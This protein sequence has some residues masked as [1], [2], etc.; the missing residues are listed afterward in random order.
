MG[1]VQRVGDANSGGGAVE[2][3]DPTVRVNNRAVALVGDSVT[4]HPCCGARRCPGIH[5]GC[6]TA[7]GTTTVKVGN[8][9]VSLND[10]ADTCGHTRSGG[11]TN[12][13]FN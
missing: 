5:C 7:G 11:S 10:D 9:A 1:D 13:R 2:N 3:G 6:V 8:K 4:S 12:V